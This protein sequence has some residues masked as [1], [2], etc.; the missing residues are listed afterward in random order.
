MDYIPIVLGIPTF[1]VNLKKIILDHFIAGSPR[2]ESLEIFENLKSSVSAYANMHTQLLDLKTLHELAQSLQVA[3]LR[4]DQIAVFLN[5]RGPF[6]DYSWTDVS[7]QWDAF[8]RFDVARFRDRRR[9][10]RSLSVFLTLQNLAT[11][12]TQEVDVFSRIEEYVTLIS[13]SIQQENY[14][15]SSRHLRSFRDLLDNTLIT[16]DGDMR[17]AATNLTDVSNQLKNKIEELL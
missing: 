12:S 7:S 8:R 13:E 1:L 11:G 15:A 10:L 6:R 3:F 4:L 17:R 5:A 14:S 9:D 16:A 2:N